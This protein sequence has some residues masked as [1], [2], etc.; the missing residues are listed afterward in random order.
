M[1]VQYICFEKNEED[2]RM[3][4][5]EFFEFIDQLNHY[6]SLRDVLNR[7]QEASRC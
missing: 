6:S 7:F 2:H 3:L 5:R 1:Y 4:H